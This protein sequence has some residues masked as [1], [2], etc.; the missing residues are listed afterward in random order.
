MPIL[1]APLVLASASTAV[2]LLISRHYFHA[3]L[4]M[5]ASAF[6]ALAL[7]NR[8]NSFLEANRK[9]IWEDEESPLKANERLAK[10]ITIIFLGIFL[11]AIFLQVVAT[12]LFGV[13]SHAS[14]LAFRNVFEAL[15]THNL[16]VLLIFIFLAALYRAG[17]LV[18]I[19]AWNA[20][21]WSETLVAHF[22]NIT[23]RQG[24]VRAIGVAL[25]IVPHLLF[26]TIAY[27]VA[28]MGGVFLSKALTKYSLSSPKFQRVSVAVLM[29]WG[30]AVMLLLLATTFEVYLAQPIFHGG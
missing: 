21:H 28:G 10:E 25:A 19:L 26:E 14:S 12:D 3:N 13:H 5:A 29:L 17:G 8:M 22:E 30:G 18:I 2:A 24:L 16:S 6:I 1:K 9:A 23:L 11:T 27:I 7:V 20:L 4:I 15:F